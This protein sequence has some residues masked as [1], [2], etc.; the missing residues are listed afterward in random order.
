MLRKFKEARIERIQKVFEESSFAFLVDFS[1]SDTVEIDQFKSAVREANA[2]MFVAKNKL[3]K[4][5]TGRIEGADWVERIAPYF[6]SSTALVFGSS[7]I[8]SC[9]KAIR[10]FHRGHDKKMAVKAIFFDNQ[11]F[12]PDKFVGFTELLSK[13]ELRARL[14]GLLMAPQTNLVRLLKAAPQ[15]FA[16][17]VKAYA[18]K[19]AG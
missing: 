3:A 18:E 9:A 15:G 10:K 17:V 19:K 7:D 16:A 14:L 5:A 11:V 13:D 4:I 1:K 2:D 12:G 6:T 8:G